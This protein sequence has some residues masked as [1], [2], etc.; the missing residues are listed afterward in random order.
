MNYKLTLIG[1]DSKSIGTVGDF[2][3]SLPNKFYINTYESLLNPKSLLRN[4]KINKL[5]GFDEEGYLII[6][7]SEIL[8]CFGTMGPMQRLVKFKS[9]VENIISYRDNVIVLSPILKSFDGEKF[10]CGNS[11]LYICD[12]AVMVCE[13]EIKIIKDKHRNDIEKRILNRY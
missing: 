9:A 2:I 8:Y 12:K 5:F 13:N 11:I 3:N 4:D 7:Y 10:R 6:D 1:Y